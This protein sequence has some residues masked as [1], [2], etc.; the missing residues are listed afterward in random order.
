MLIRSIN[1]YDS[2]YYLYKEKYRINNSLKEVKNMND[3]FKCKY[4]KDLINSKKWQYGP[5]NDPQ[6]IL[7]RDL[8]WRPQEEHT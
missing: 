7:W 8:T 3:K 6:G 5:E 4:Y 1:W 2:E